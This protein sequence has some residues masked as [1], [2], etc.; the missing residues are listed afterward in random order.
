MDGIDDAIFVVKPHFVAPFLGIAVCV[1]CCVVI[2]HVA[3]SD[4]GVKG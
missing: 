2:D 4:I 3:I 1:F